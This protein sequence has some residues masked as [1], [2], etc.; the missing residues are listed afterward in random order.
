MPAGRRAA[1]RRRR[2]RIGCHG[3]AH[4]GRQCPLRPVG[5]RAQRPDEPPEPGC[6][7]TCS[8]KPVITRTDHNSNRNQPR[9]P[10][11]VAPAVEFT[12]NVRS[13]HPD[14]APLGVA[15]DERADSV[16]SKAC[17][18][19]P[20]DISGADAAPPRHMAS[21]GKAG[22]KRCHPLD[23]LEWI[24]RRHQPPHLVERQR[25]DRGQAQPPVPAMRRIE[26]STEEAGESQRKDFQSD[27]A[28]TT[29]T[30]WIASPR[31]T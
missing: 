19:S 25:V 22:L 31:T 29:R 14:E 3:Q 8:S 28:C 23:R 6:R 26:R 21:A 12:D 5:V 27:I 30:M 17:A 16:D 13:H 10:P 11:P 2:S 20:L 24:A 9:E 18:H 4:D 1:Q 15:S 7:R